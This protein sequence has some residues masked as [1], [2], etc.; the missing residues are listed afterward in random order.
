MTSPLVVGL[1]SNFGGMTT[2]LLGT[3]VLDKI[4]LNNQL[5]TLIIDSS[6]DLPA[7]REVEFAIFLVPVTSSISTTPHQN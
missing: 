7:K 6:T 5:E 2:S 1:S 4:E 3:A